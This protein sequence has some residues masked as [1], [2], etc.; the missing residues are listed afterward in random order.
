MTAGTRAIAILLLPLAAASASAADLYVSQ[1]GADG[2]AG[3]S[4]ETS[5]LTVNHAA[6]AAQSGT[7]ILVG[8]GTYPEEVYRLSADWV[9]FSALGDV[10]LEGSW[11]AWTGIWFNR[12]NYPT[13]KGFSIQTYWRPVRC[14]NTTGATF[15]GCRIG[16]GLYQGIGHGVDFSASTDWRLQDCE[17][18]SMHSFANFNGTVRAGPR[19]GP[20]I[21][22]CTFRDKYPFPVSAITLTQRDVTITDSTFSPMSAGIDALYLGSGA[23]NVKVKN[24]NFSQAHCGINWTQGYDISVQGCLFHDLTYYAVSSTY[25]GNIDFINNVLVDNFGGLLFAKPPD[26]GY[27]FKIY[28]N[29]VAWN[30]ETAI[31]APATSGS[32]RIL[33]GNNDV[34]GNGDNTFSVCSDVG[35]NIAFDSAFCVGT[36]GDYGLWN[37]PEVIDGG[38]WAQASA[39]TDWTGET[40]TDHGGGKT[41]IGIYDRGRCFTPSPTPYGYKTPTPSPTLT[42]EPSA[43][44]TPEPT[45]TPTPEPSATPTPEPTKT[46]EPTA[47]TTPSPEPTLTPSP[48]A[49]PTPSSPATPTPHAPS[50]TPT[51]GPSAPP[52]QAVIASGDY[53]G[54]G[55]ADLAIFRPAFSLWSVRN[56]TR[57]YFGASGDQPAPGDFDGDGTAEI[58]IFR[59]ASGLWSVSGVSRVYF[60]GSEDRAA[61]ADFDGNGTC[62]LAIFRGEGGLWSVRFL[63]RFYFGSSG[64]WPLPGDYAGGGAAAAGLYRP[65]SG[66]WLIH[67]LTRFY[68]GSSE[69]R[70]VPGDYTG[71][72]ER[73]GA[74]FRPCTGMW[75]LRDLTRIYF[76]NCLDIPRPGDFDG[77]GT[78]DLAVFRG[79]SGLW[80][81]RGL[82]RAYFG[83]TGDVPVTR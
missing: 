21:D 16:G 27:R 35:G 52:E 68:F 61:P 8:A 72:G 31:F 2:N 24:S 26:A 48:S 29:I 20:S 9:T 15:Q 76:G 70:P 11:G 25:T 38:S 75:S 67:G 49:S 39:V 12:V 63:T 47:T 57:L 23:I 73:T 69:D 77:D 82:S 41:A 50:P 56:L 44:P 18:M 51:C 30:A 62:D 79:S 10:V 34:F 36:M 60:G 42:P 28:N 22:R 83:S 13:V 32:A 53:D 59:P 78:D 81:L 3:T 46:P 43:T 55:A 66:Q 19:G 74:V 17:I 4:W 37:Y 7:T 6:A 64:D 1:T 80:S 65:A 71:A 5:Y 58:A 40:F 33:V 14:Y 45:K 54:N